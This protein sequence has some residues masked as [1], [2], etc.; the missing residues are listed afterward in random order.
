[1][2]KSLK[3]KEFCDT[4]HEIAGAAGKASLPFEQCEQKRHFTFAP[5]QV[6]DAS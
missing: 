1:V 6:D 3:L 2:R 4:V 5:S